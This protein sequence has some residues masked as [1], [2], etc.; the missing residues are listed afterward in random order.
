MKFIFLKEEY[1]EELAKLINE[2]F[3]RNCSK[4]NLRYIVDND[5]IK[6]I[7]ALDGNQVIGNVFIDIMLDPTTKQKYFYLS[8]ICVSK[9]YQNRGIGK[10]I[11][12]EIENFALKED[13]SYILLT[14]SD[15]RVN[16]HKLYYSA[17]F[18]IKETNLFIKNINN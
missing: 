8:Y 10:R 2:C 7:V 15:K 17:G 14:S 18:E 3:N 12:Q 6:S 5:N 13:C 16:A 4:E 1:L 11:M 9:N